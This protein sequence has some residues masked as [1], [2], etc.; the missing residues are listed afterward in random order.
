MV[1]PPEGK[2]HRCVP[3]VRLYVAQTQEIKKGPKPLWLL[4][5]YVCAAMP[6]Y[7][8]P[9]YSFNDLSNVEIH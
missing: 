3:A 5:D 4:A 7:E 1:F 6:E 8:E 9:E 2:T